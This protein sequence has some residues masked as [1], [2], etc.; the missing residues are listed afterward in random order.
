MAFNQKGATGNHY[1]TEW[2]ERMLNKIVGEKYAIDSGETTAK[3]LATLVLYS[4]RYPI[5]IQNG[6]I[7]TL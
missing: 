1:N 3:M 2:L 6:D 4:W 5:F 7:N